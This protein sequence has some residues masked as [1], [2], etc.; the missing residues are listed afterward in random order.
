MLELFF[1]FLQALFA[2]YL[3]YYLVAF[4]SGAPFVPSTSPATRKMIELAGIKKGSIVYDLG[5][6]DGRLLAQAAGKGA[7]ATGYEIN[8]LL[9]FYSVLR[10][11]PLILRGRV[12]S[13]WGNFWK[14]NLSQADIVFVYLLPWRMDALATKLTKE[15]KPGSVVVTNSFI[16]PGW[17]MWKQDAASHVYAYKIP[18][19]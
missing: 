4:V 11:L 16:F 10:F 1:L 18:I 19:H 2:I 8:P 17:K 3:I 13:V 9:V 6:G 15:L 5:S 12:K 7:I 14:Q